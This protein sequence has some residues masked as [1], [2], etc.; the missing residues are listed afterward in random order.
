MTKELA[1]NLS[2]RTTSTGWWV[3]LS[4]DCWW[5]LATCRNGRSLFSAKSLT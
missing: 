3:F 2:I 1:L 4:G 5:H